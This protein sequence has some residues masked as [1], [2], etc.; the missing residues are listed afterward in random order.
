MIL[1][2]W[3]AY[4]M[5]VKIP[6][7]T[8]NTISPYKKEIY[9][10]YVL[11]R[12]FPVS[13]GSSVP[14]IEEIVSSVDNLNIK[15]LL[16]I[17]NQTEFA[18]KYKVENSTLTNWNNLIEKRHV[19]DDSKKWAQSLIKNMILSLYDHALETGNPAAFKLWF[20]VV[21]GPNYNKDTRKDQPPQVTF[22]GLFFE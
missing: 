2:E 22:N 4:F 17:K 7:N 8:K 11:W 10:L 5:V 3:Y 9:E 1:N 14:E 13:L 19:I 18:K 15:D 12:S 16:Q 20:E 21:C 6:N